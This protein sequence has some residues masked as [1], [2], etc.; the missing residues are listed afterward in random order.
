MASER[1]AWEWESFEW[2]P[3]DQWAEA[4]IAR[5]AEVGACAGKAMGYPASWEGNLHQPGLCCDSQPV[6]RMANTV[7][8]EIR[9]PWLHTLRLP[10]GSNGNA[11]AT[12]A[13]TIY[14]AAQIKIGTGVVVWTG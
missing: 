1:G 9:E 5:H 11:K 3:L 6:S 14:S 13:M 7:S 4:E 2:E 8:R 10:N 12:M